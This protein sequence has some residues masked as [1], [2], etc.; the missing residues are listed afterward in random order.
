MCCL[1]ARK[2]CRSEMTKLTEDNLL[3]MLHACSSSQSRTIKV[4][5]TAVWFKPTLLLHSLIFQGR[6]G[7]LRRSACSQSSK[8]SQFPGSY[9]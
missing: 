8:P 4:V 1:C 7:V 6:S 9:L 3:L 2:Q 5:Y